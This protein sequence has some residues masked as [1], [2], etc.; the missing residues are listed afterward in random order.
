MA[1]RVRHVKESGGA[2][3]AKDLAYFSL[4]VAALPFTVAEAAFRAGSTVMIEA[5]RR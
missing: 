5:R 1:R 2:R 3:L 4:V